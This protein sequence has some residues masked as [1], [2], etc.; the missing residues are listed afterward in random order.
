MTALRAA[1]YS[2]N[3]VVCSRTDLG[4]HARMQVL[5]LRVLAGEPLAE[6]APRLNAVLPP[7]VG[8]VCASLAGPKFHAAWSS[9]GKEYR[10]RLLLAD[11]ARWGDAAW[12]VEVDP[13]A[14]RS[15][16]ELVVGTRDFSIFHDASSTVR[17][18]TIT[19]AELVTIGP[20]LEV[21]LRGD[22]FGRYM[23]RQLVGGMVDVATGAS[24]LGAFAAALEG[25]G[26]LRPTRAP[27]KGLVLW[28]I[29]YPP[30]DDPFA[31]VRHCPTG[32]PEVPPFADGW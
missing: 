26:R 4:V 3:P 5:S 20:R 32:V 27:A 2:R 17:P 29:H 11:D 6:L 13:S 10:Y 22:A 18:R 16:L 15:A 31:S 21:R 9:V 23:V 14:L 25:H 28:E 30:A 19:S 8:V 1:G 12:R 24:T 7:T